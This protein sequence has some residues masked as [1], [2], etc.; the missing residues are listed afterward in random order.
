MAKPEFCQTAQCTYFSNDACRI[1][2]EIKKGWSQYTRRDEM[3]SIY[4]EE[5]R[6]EPEVVRNRCAQI[7]NK[8]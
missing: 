5:A 6:I 8:G 2:V 4:L 7:L 3:R 1:N